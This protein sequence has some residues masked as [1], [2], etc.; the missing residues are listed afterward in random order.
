M[1]VWQRGQIKFARTGAESLQSCHALER[2]KWRLL[3]RSCN[4]TA[5]LASGELGNEKSGGSRDVQL[6]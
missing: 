5:L 6:L 3:S 1:D 2:D 4:D